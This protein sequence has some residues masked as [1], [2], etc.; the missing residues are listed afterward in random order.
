MRVFYWA[1]YYGRVDTLKIMVE[2]LKWSP[3]IKSFRLRSII[4]AAI[5]GDQVDAVRFL[6]GEYKYDQI[7]QN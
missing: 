3:F 1:A 7:K 2:F 4:S 6:V 5:L